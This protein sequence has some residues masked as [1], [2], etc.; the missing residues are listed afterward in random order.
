MV[1]FSNKNKKF[2]LFRFL[3]NF[4]M[5]LIILIE[6]YKTLSGMKH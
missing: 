6:M 4:D 1:A 3:K 5:K 2:V